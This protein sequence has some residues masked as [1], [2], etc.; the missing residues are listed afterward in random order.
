M[1]DEDED[2]DGVG[3]GEGVACA[4]PVLPLDWLVVESSATPLDPLATTAGW[5]A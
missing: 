3:D 5:P 4:A 2:E 1:A